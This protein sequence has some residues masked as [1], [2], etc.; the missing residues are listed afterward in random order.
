MLSYLFLLLSFKHSIESSLYV[1]FFVVFWLR[2]IYLQISWYDSLNLA[3]DSCSYQAS[4]PLFTGNYSWLNGRFCRN[5]IR[6]ILFGDLHELFTTPK[7]LEY[8]K[9]P[10]KWMPR[11]ILISTVGL[12]T[13]C[14]AS[15]R[16]WWNIL[17]K[18]C[19]NLCGFVLQS[20]ISRYVLLLFPGNF[21]E[22]S[23]RKSW[24]K[25]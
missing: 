23:A 11:I 2:R 16:C 14:Y 22:K 12:I 21:E 13:W 5:S 4:F 1:L 19:W 9:P 15:L 18:F 7:K 17:V 25:V 3:C 10:A 20:W 6:F 24:K 8:L